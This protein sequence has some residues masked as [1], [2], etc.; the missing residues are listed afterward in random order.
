[1][2]IDCARVSTHDQNLAGV[3]ENYALGQHGQPQ[4]F[5]GRAWL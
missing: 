4:S 2:L 5:A 3:V 1:M